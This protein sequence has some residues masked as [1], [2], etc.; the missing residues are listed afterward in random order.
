MWYPTDIEF[1]DLGFASYTAN[2]K[3]E[4]IT[5]I[6]LNIPGIHNVYNS[7]AAFAL[8]YEYGLSKDT[9]VK[10]IYNYRGTDRRF[11]HKGS[12]NGVAVVDDYAHHPTEIAATI[13][14]ARGMDIKELW[15]VFQPHTYTRTKALLNEFAD[16]LS[17]S[18]KVVLADIYASREKDTGLVSSADLAEKLKT[19]GTDV[20]YCPGEL[21]E[22]ENYVRKNCPEGSLLIT[23]GAGD[24]F[25]IGESLVSEDK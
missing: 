21:K 13:N 15:I 22:V 12:Y 19:L 9:I 20:A 8:A 24:V 18:D 25:K 10:G 23:M 6:H 3:G 4:E 7:L 2:C 17:K 14:S 1:D 5:Q 11:Q 16:A